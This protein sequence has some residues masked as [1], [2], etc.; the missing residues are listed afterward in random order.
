MWSCISCKDLMT[1]MYKMRRNQVKG[2]VKCFSSS[3]S[4]EDRTGQSAAT[5]SIKSLFSGFG[6]TLISNMSHDDGSLW[7]M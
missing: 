7:K 2:E 1:H 6:G 3:I 5:R 4:F